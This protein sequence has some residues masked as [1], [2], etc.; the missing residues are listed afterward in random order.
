MSSVWQGR[1]CVCPLEVGYISETPFPKVR[2]SF[3]LC[4][5]RLG[6]LLLA[7]GS[8]HEIALHRRIVL[9]AFVLLWLNLKIRWYWDYWKNWVVF[10]ELRTVSI[11][12]TLTSSN[13]TLIPLSSSIFSAV[14]QLNR[15]IEGNPKRSLRFSWRNF[16]VTASPGYPDPHLLVNSWEYFH[17]N[18][19]TN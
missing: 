11:E 10:V 9:D 17:T 5:I 14:F 8:H 16:F 19:A 15:T 6:S 7:S 4:R 12:W 18:N 2:M 3:T 1:K 13:L